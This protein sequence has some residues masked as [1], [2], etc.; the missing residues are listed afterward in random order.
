MI[1]TLCLS[2]CLASAARAG[3]GARLL[4]LGGS[5]TE[6][7]VAL[8]VGRWLIARDSTSNWPESVLSLPDVGNIRA[9]SPEDV[10]ALDPG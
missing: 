9:P 1:R 6:N 10:L 2:F 7:A 4:T 8:G 3:E 5:V